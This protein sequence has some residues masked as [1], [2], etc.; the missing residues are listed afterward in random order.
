VRARAL[1]VARE[2]APYLAIA[3]GAFVLR[4]IDLDARPLHHDES[5]H[6]WFAW[7]LVT[8]EG[9]RYDPVF[10]GPVQFYLLALADLIFG[11]HD[12]VAR[13]PAVTGGSLIVFLPFFLRR[14]LGRP[15]TL[16]TSV[17]I[18]ISPSFLYVSRFAREDIHVEALTFG[19]LIVLVRFLERPARWHPIAGL[20]LFAVAFATKESTYITAFLVVLLLVGAFGLQALRSRRVGERM[21]EARLVREV[22]ALGLDVWVW[23]VCAFLVVFTILFSTFLAH[24]G[25]LR[26]GLTGS[27]SYWLSQQDVAR[28]GQP[29]YYY[30]VLLL[31]YEWLCV[32][33]GIV[34]IVGVM[35]RATAARVAIVWTFA[36]SLA[37]YSWASERMPW[38]VIH[39]LLPLTLLAGLGLQEIWKR[40]ASLGFRALLALV[41]V[42]AGATLA[43]AVRVAYVSPTDPRELLTQ[44]Q[45]AD[46]VP[47]V[48]T[49]LFALDRRMRAGGGPPLAITVD[50]FGGTGWPWSWYLRDLPVNYPDMSTPAYVPQGDVI[51]VSDLTNGSVAPKLVGYEA[52]RMHLR[53]WWVTEYGAASPADWARWLVSRRAWNPTG[54]MDGWV[55]V[56]R[57]R[58][59]SL[60][61]PL[62]ALP[63]D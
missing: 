15:A 29:P 21:R 32:V 18:A 20:A 30:V 47:R 40:R 59:A 51:L 63:K 56:K 48:R 3:V 23:G 9:Y 42:G 55:Y 11:V 33:L 14:Q 41:V 19:I 17:L 52:R 1:A 7:R 5:E 53:V 2:A 25:G 45:T 16:A 36:G 50:S 34:G 60:A 39:P 31:G 8:G 12:A 26:E 24:P 57:G 35:R 49:M 58:V 44:V 38:L 27:I 6:A 61:G 13:V 37:V 28:G 54:G 4:A 43:S 10:H 46:D 22:R 62:L